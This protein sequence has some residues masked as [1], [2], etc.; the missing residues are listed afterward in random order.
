MRWLVDN[1]QKSFIVKLTGDG[2]LADLASVQA[3]AERAVA[4]PLSEKGC[5]E[6]AHHLWRYLHEGGGPGI[7][8]DEEAPH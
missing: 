5:A 1:A 3:A 8:P 6:L 4:L 2:L 7:D